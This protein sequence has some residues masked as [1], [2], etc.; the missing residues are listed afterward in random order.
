MFVIAKGN[1]G[2]IR[3]KKVYQTVFVAVILLVSLTLFLIGYKTAG[4]TRN[5]LTVFAVLGVLP[6][7]KALVNLVLFLPYRSWD[8]VH[9]EEIL[10]VIGENGHLYSDLVFTSSKHVMHLDSLYVNG[11]E[12]IGLT[13]SQNS[14][15]KVGK[16]DEISEYFTGTM[17]KQ[18]VGVHMHIFTEFSKYRD[19]A[20][21]LSD[22]DAEIPQQLE[23]F[24]RT[25]LV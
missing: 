16:L 13:E 14:D 18:G 9:F 22:E 6:G 3:R 2:Y 4:T 8:K 11:N 7:A 1:N 17:K 25:V 20:E 5:L 15:K 19:R 12:I 24:I 23:E 10:G 21:A